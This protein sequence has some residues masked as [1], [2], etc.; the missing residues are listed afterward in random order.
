MVEEYWG[1][2]NE[3]RALSGSSGNT[4]IGHFNKSYLQGGQPRIRDDA[5]IGKEVV[6]THLSREGHVHY[7]VGF[8][9]V[10]SWSQSGLVRCQ[11]PVRWFMS[12]RR[13]TW[14]VWEHHTSSAGNVKGCF[15]SINY[16]FSASYTLFHL[17]PT[18]LL[19]L[20]FNRQV[21]LF[22]TP[23]TIAPHAPLSSNI[24]QSLLKFMSIELVML[25]NHLSLCCLLL[26]LP[27][28]LSQHQ[29]F[30]NE[31]ALC[32]KWPKYWSLSIFP[33]NEYSGLSSFRTD[34]FDLLGGY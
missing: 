4:M 33:S 27:L 18:I 31:I 2:A 10:L 25:S 3:A 11:C 12:S 17:N 16:V 26:L 8:S 32:I 34:W 23:W 13:T 7:F 21:Q 1:E 14:P 24:S 15:L 28:N 29:G 19:F 30:S 22:T 6:A 5:V 9:L 20:S